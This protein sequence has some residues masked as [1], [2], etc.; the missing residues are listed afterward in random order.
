MTSLL[1]VLWG[2]LYKKCDWRSFLLIQHIWRISA[3]PPSIS[4]HQDVWA[5]QQ[6]Q[7]PPCSKGVSLLY[8]I[9]DSDWK[10]SSLFLPSY[11]FLL[12]SLFPSAFFCSAFPSFVSVVRQMKESH[13][14][15]G[16]SELSAVMLIYVLIWHT[17]THTF[18][19]CSALHLNFTP[20]TRLVIRLIFFCTPCTYV[21]SFSSSLMKGFGNVFFCLF[22]YF[23][24][25][26]MKLLQMLKTMIEVKAIWFI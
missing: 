22:L 14:H 5:T 2:S 15:Q 24:I 10:S 6:L 12:T 23:F 21:V 9:N 3:Q 7:I 20:M 17:Y 26:R 1:G 13:L 4:Q 11:V 8:S 25:Q 18:F 19:F 16:D